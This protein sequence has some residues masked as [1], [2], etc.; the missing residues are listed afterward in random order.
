[1]PRKKKASKRIT[2][3]A[4]NPAKRLLVRNSV[5]QQYSNKA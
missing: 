1:M 3:L 5:N 4:D 2:A